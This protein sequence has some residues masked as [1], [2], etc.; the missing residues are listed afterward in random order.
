MKRGGEGPEYI[1]KTVDKAVIV[2]ALSALE[3]KA[4]RYVKAADRETLYGYDSGRGSVLN[5][6]ARALRYA[7][8]H[9]ERD[10]YL[11]E[12]HPSRGWW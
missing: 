11:L 3:A 6:R 2:A 4:E 8:D 1:R 5:A 7:V 12:G 9:L 10:L